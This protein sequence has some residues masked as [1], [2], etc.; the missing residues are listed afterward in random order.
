VQ[1]E[2]DKYKVT[3]NRIEEIKNR[4]EIEVINYSYSR[5]GFGYTDWKPLE[6][7][8]FTKKS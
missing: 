3:R 2:G 1:L 6:E 7:G 8:F 5:E 4:E